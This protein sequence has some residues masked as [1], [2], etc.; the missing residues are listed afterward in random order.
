MKTFSEDTKSLVIPSG[1]KM[2]R[3]P[4][5]HELFS[6]E[7][8]LPDKDANQNLITPWFSRGTYVFDGL[9]WEKL[10]DTKRQTKSA[11]IAANMF[12][13]ETTSSIDA[14]QHNEGE[15]LATVTID[16]SNRKAVISGTGSVWVDCSMSANVWLSVFRGHTLVGHG[17]T[18]A[19]R[20]SAR[21]VAV[22]FCDMPMTG[23]PLTYQLRVHTDTKCELYINRSTRMPFNGGASSAFIVMENS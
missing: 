14:C 9:N 19:E 7:A 15:L 23:E 17:L 5:A 13:V 18:F 20:K 22:S 10:N 3:A 21:S 4:R 8:D 16:P 6:L 11:M 12:E 1:H 2:P